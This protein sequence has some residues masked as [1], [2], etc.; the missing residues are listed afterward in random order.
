MKHVTC[1]NCGK[2]G[3]VQDNCRSKGISGG[4]KPNNGSGNG[5]MVFEITEKKTRE[6]ETRFT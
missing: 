6:S 2:V 5:I 4:D 3:H 1:Y